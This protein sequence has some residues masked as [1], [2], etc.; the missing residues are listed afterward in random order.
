MTDEDALWS[1]GALL[2]GLPLGSWLAVREMYR[3]KDGNEH[4]HDPNT[5]TRNNICADCRY[6][7]EE[8]WYVPCPVK[9]CTEGKPLPLERAWRRYD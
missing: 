1:L 6:T 5:H 9:D 2:L 8:T 4:S 3:D 7:Y